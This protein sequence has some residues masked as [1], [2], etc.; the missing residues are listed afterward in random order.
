V[1]CKQEKNRRILFV[2]GLNDSEIVIIKIDI[3]YQNCFT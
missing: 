1:D 2:P 3:F